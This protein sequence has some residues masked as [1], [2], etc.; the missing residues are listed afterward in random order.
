MPHRVARLARIGLLLGLVFA[1]AQSFTTYAAADSL[2]GNTWLQIAS[3]KDLNQAI[4]I[5]QQYSGAKVVLS[6]NGWYAVVL[7]PYS[8]ADLAQIRASYDGKT[9]LPDDAYVTHGNFY[10]VMVWNPG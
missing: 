9:S 2:R 5:A 4:T 3:R 10:T 8:F 6:R 1:S 7:G